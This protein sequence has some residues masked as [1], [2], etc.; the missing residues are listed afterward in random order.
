MTYSPFWNNLNANVKVYICPSD[1]SN[2]AGTGWNSGLSSYAYNA[3]V[4]PIDWTTQHRYPASIQ[5]GTS[6]TIFFTEQRA[7]CTG[8]WPDWGPSIADPNWPQPTGPASI[9]LV[10]PPGNGCPYSDGSQY[11]A[12]SVHTAGILVG[13]GDGSSRLVSQSVSGNTWWAALTCDQSD[14]LGNDW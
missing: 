2:I 4:F 5:D 12:T 10:Q 3:Q 1:P 6:Q 14:I 13:L 9:F 11:R 7:A 8:F